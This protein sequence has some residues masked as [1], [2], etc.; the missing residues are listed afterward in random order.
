MNGAI[1]DAMFTFAEPSFPPKQ[2]TF[3]MGTAVIT[4]LPVTPTVAV[5]VAVHPLESVTLTS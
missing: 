4:G 5:I 1:P 2:F 3:P